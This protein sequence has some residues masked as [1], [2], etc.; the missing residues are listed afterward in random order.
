MGNI[1]RYVANSPLILLYNSPIDLCQY[2][3]SG[4]DLERM[5]RGRLLELGTR[6]SIF[7]T[8]HTAL[9]DG[10]TGLLVKLARISVGSD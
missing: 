4:I 7:A 3:R 8:D 9:E 10:K 1:W 6:D 2:L 5:C